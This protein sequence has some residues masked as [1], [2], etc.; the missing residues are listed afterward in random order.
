MALVVAVPRRKALGEAPP[1]AVGAL[2]AALLLALTWGCWIAAVH[3]KRLPRAMKRRPQIVLHACFWI[4][5]VVLWRVPAE[6]VALR[7]GLML[8]A[9][10]LPFLLWRLGYL[11]KSGQRG[12]AAGT[13]FGDHAFYLWPLWG[14]SETPYGKGY[15]YLTQHEARTPDVFARTQLAGMRLL[16]LAA[17]WSATENLMTAVLYGAGP[18]ATPFRQWSLGVPELDE[19]I[20]GT[21]APLWLAWLSIYCEL[22]RSTLVIAA[23]GH[24]YIGVLRLFG[25]YVFRNT[26]RPLLAESV[27]EFWNRF[28]YYFK[29]LLVEF[30]FYPTYA[31]WRVRPELRTFLAVFAAA[32]IGNLYYHLVQSH[33][34]LIAGDASAVWDAFRS[35]ALYSFLLACGVYVSMLREQRRRGRGVPARSTVRRVVS[36][37]GVWT[38]FA[39]LHVWGIGRET[40]TFAARIDFC[41]SLLALR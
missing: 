38:F 28:Y 14:G 5:L 33:R 19:L 13:A 7:R 18:W 22:V 27:V 12:K 1:L 30:F 11:L 26:Y 41:R 24:V 8:V 37:V 2:V 29:E 36:I 9:V 16:L 25:F 40:P 23:K 32:G 35:R 17:L 6:L 10:V 3:F 39:L 4:V 15:D 21:A 34:L 20:A 31:R